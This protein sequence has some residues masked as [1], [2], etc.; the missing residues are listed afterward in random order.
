MTEKFEM[1]FDSTFE[2]VP[3]ISKMSINWVKIIYITKNI[4]NENK[5]I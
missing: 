3:N 1:K 4:I 5:N 2:S